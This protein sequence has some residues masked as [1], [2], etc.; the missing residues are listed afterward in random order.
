MLAVVVA[1][2]ALAS[3]K[4]LYPVPN[5]SPSLPGRASVDAL[6]TD[7]RVLVWNVHKGVDVGF[8][9]EFA[10]RAA[11]RDLVLLQEVY[12][13]PAVVDA[14]DERPGMRWEMGASFVYARRRDRPATGV[15]IG[16]VAAPVSAPVVVRAPI[17]EAIIGTPKAALLVE[18]PLRGSD[19][20]L[21]VV[22]VHAINFRRAPHLADQLE[23]LVQR[24]A[25]HS[26]PV[27]LAGDFN[28]HHAPRMCVLHR[29]VGRLGLR[30]AFDNPSRAWRRRS[31]DDSR[32]THRGWPLDHLFVRGLTIRG[33][34]VDGSAHGSDHQ[35]LLVRLRYKP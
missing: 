21:L 8:K 6:P 11:D 30:S 14:L 15:A 9:R 19:E 7:F 3:C 10:D 20:H 22:D 26:G 25:A 33:A 29:L 2:L 12:E 5:E 23:P 4:S 24:I 13:G 27:I 31:P 18:Y 1:G 34:Q 35:P 28:T 32:T 16:S 17:R